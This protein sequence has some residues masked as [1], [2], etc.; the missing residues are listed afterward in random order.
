MSCFFFFFY[1]NLTKCLL[2]PEPTSAPLD[3]FIEDKNDTSVTIIWSQ[4]EVVGD[5]GLDGYTIEICKDGSK[6]RPTS[7]LVLTLGL[8]TSRGQSIYTPECLTCD[9]CA[10]FTH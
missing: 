6:S 5:S 2:S 1:P 3:L 10:N 8:S 9:R 4:P 7:N